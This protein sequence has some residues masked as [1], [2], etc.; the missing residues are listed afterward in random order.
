MYQL[1]QIYV[2]TVT[3]VTKCRKLCCITENFKDWLHLYLHKGQLVARKLIN[4]TSEMQLN[5]YFIVWYDNNE[6]DFICEKQWQ[7]T[8]EDWFHKYSC[9]SSRASEICQ[10]PS[11][12]T[13]VTHPQ[14]NLYIKRW[15]RLVI[16]PPRA[17]ST[18][19]AMWPSQNLSFLSSCSACLANLHQAF[20]SSSCWDLWNQLYEESHLFLAIGA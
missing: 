11:L 12:V 17:S 3:N 8:N 16:N 13:S 14:S 10:R 7:R 19:L 9:R 4:F 2:P 18:D 1:W 20:L 5:L 15:T 6:D